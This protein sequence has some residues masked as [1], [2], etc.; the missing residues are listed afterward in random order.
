MKNLT[1]LII[2]SLFVLAF[3]GCGETATNTAVN[4]NTVANNTA[5]NSANN[6]MTTTPATNSPEAPPKSDLKPAD[7]DPNKPIP[8]A[9]VKAAYIADKSAWHGKE[10]SV[11]GDY[12]GKGKSTEGGKES[13]FYVSITDA[14]KK[15]MGTCHLDKEASDELSK[16]PANHVFK[17]TIVED[18]G[19]IVEQVKLKPCQIVK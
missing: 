12:F 16:Q 7:V 6:A 17:G 11:T 9:E 5:T 15:L 14:G 2:L 19:A 18:K 10:V 1:L 3:A 4:V 8:I 13:G